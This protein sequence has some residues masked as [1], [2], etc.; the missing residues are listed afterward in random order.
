MKLLTSKPSAMNVTATSALLL[1]LVTGPAMMTPAH[2]TGI[3][4]LDVANL[5][6]NVITS[7]EAIAQTLKQIQQYQTG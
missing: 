2:A 6:Q 1:S 7:I 4:V 3:P 5:S